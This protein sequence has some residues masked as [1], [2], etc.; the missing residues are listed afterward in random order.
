MTELLEQALRK[1]A[2]LPC[3]EQGA[4]VSQIIKTLEDEA[5]WKEELARTSD[6]L[7]RLA[8]D[9]QRES[10]GGDTRPLDQLL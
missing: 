1:V 3:D 7:R 4:I 2:A 6:K 8:N 10:K 5:I 9:A